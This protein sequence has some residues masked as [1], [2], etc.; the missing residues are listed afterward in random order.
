M[1]T[2]NLKIQSEDVEILDT[3]IGKNQQDMK[4]VFSEELSD[5]DFSLKDFRNNW[6]YGTPIFKLEDENF[7]IVLEMVADGMYVQATLF[8]VKED[9]THQ[10]SV[11][12]PNHESIIGEFNL[13]DKNNKT[14]VLKS[15]QNNDIY[16]HKIVVCSF[17]NDFITES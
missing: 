5:Y 12:S 9:G 11:S 1:T 17:Q 7:K 6:Y 14:I 3:L 2:I 16:N 8:E 13:K 15:F 4:K 10:I